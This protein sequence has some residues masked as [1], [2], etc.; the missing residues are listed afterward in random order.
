MRC[1]IPA[2]QSLSSH[3]GY[4]SNWHGIEEICSGHPCFVIEAKR[5]N[6]DAGNF[7]TTYYYDYSILLLVIINLLLFVIYKLKFIIGICI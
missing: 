5:K 2:H 1:R 7:M 4:Q 6:E 3:L